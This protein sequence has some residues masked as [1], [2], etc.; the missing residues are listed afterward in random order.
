MAAPD[1]MAKLPHLQQAQHTI[2][3]CY[4]TRIPSIA[5]WEGTYMLQLG[6][7]MPLGVDTMDHNP[8][9]LSQELAN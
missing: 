6:Y 7:T 2:S 9:A 1:D 8:L 4:A 5:Q 3:S